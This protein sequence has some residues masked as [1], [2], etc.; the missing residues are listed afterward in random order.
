L[1]SS[2]DSGEFGFVEQKAQNTRSLGLSVGEARPKK[3]L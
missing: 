1:V 3:R 2:L